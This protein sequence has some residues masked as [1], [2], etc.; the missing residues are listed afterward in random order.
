MKHTHLCRYATVVAS[1]LTLGTSALWAQAA[2]APSSTSPSAA[3]SEPT[4]RRN[5]VVLDETGQT[6]VKLTPFEVSSERETGYTAATTLAG[7]R[8]N[9]ELRD[10]GNAVSVITA[11]FL[12]DTGAV[13]N[14]S[15]LQYLTGT[16]VGNVHGNFTG[17]GDGALL[18]ET[19]KF[20]NPNQNTR[21]RGLAA[22]DNTRDYFLT[23]I[24]WDG[25]NV[26]RVDL[27]RGPNSILFGL[28]SP[29]G[30]I[31]TNTRQ[32]GFKNT[33]EAEFRF[34]SFESHRTTL[35]VNRVL[36]KDQ[37]AVRVSALR[38]D[39]K[40]K[41]EPAYDLDRRVFGALRF[42][43]AFLKRA[44]AR[45]IFKATVES[46]K[47]TSNRPRTLPPIDLITPWFQTGTYQ[48]RFANGSPRT[49]NNLNRETFNPFQLQDDN[50]GRPN[51]GQQRPSINGG[52]NAGQPNP[53]YNP[54]IG[55]F[56]QSFGGPLSYF[57]GGANTPAHFLSEI[58]AT[59][60]IGPTGAIDGNV[61]G[62]AF[63]RQGGIAP[64]ATFARNAN[65]PWSEFGVYKHNS[66]T[67]AS[68]F[69]FYKN[70]LDGPN[71][72]EW[73]NFTTYNLNLA[74]TFLNEKIGFEAVY[75][76][77]RYRN[78]QLSF[79]TDGRQA[80]HIDLNNVYTDGTPAGLNGEP[81]QNGTPNPNV[82]RPF[83]SD[84]GQF[85]NNSTKN[86]R[87]S[88]RGTVFA[89]HNFATENRR[90]LL[91]RILGRHT[92]TG[93]FAR[94]ELERDQ[95]EWQR[96]A[97]LDP[98][99]RTFIGAPSSI[100]FTDNL[101]APNPVIYLGDSLLNRAGS[102]GVNIPR[103]GLAA[104]PTSGTIRAFDS[105]WA[106]R[107]GVDPAAPWENEYYPVGHASRLSTQA[108][109]PANY[110]GW[111]S[112][113]LEITDSERTPGGRDALTTRARLT[114]SRISSRALVWQG[115]FWDKAIIGNIGWRRD[116]AQSWS[117]ERRADASPGFGQVDLGP[118]FRLPDNPNNRVE[119]SSRSYSIVSHLNQLPFVREWA[120]RAPVNVS[121]FYNKA[122]NFQPE[123]ARVDVYGSPLP[124]PAGQ[125]HDR[126]V[127]IE[128]KDGRFS[129][130]VNKYKTTITDGTS[131]ALAGAWFI[132]SSQAWG[133]NWANIFEHNLGGDT[134]STQGQ[135]NAGRYTY[136]P[137]PGETQEDADRRETAAVSAWRAWQRSVDP[138]F[139]Q[140]WGLNL[141]NLDRSLSAS[142]P[143]GFSVTEDYVSQGYEI[144]FNA[145]ATKNWRLTFNAS[146]T[147]A[148][149]QNIGGAALSQFIEAYE[150]ALRTTPAGDLRIWWGGA[151]NE[152]TL[153]QWNNNIGSEYAARK[154]QEGTNVPELR[155]WRFNV[156]TNYDFHE[157]RLRGLNV[158]GGLRW[159]DEV[160]I[161]YP[162]IAS[163][164]AGQANFDLSK[165]FFGPAE[166]NVDLWVGYGRR[167]VWRNVDWRIQ[168]NV[169]NAFAGNELIPITTQPDGTPAGYRIA[170]YQTWT[171]SNT[172]KF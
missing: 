106:N 75:N 171:V 111:R 166:T 146:K 80:I 30:I 17:V 28:G 172:F 96:W 9:T 87:E 128:T 149:R 123:A 41:Q 99:Y 39:E 158:G 154:L 3:S 122:D 138:R 141:N 54:W 70:L 84:S 42:E 68:V 108:E 153:F 170:P 93:L 103:A 36:L 20:T 15:L 23:D 16:E 117:F 143:P 145:Q 4:T 21:V 10:I 24:P 55:N 161:G 114:K 167:K 152:T 156:V 74:Q 94:D 78:G 8:L 72:N 22:A 83:I 64:Y 157:G 88:M 147:E 86:E 73:Q 168:L 32:A 137:A 144:E 11:Q 43:P 44:N 13:S 62:F 66:L 50:T 56:A 136:S 135:G 90:N 33:A 119:G 132:G 120:R 25:Y 52:P 130:K 6:I 126:G 71:K 112:V 46:G 34:G 67:D 116:V 97:I 31:N 79:M 105:T 49:F 51:H 148:V 35:D 134:I 100:R 125:T 129:L 121:V 82:G 60:G 18:N 110:V 92:L 81:F 113:P 169:R 14:E 95:R 155:E 40:F 142:A 140:V 47:I 48:G 85:G 26:D 45:T 165:P 76:Q 124:A 53:A 118:T 159:Q 102:S 131:S 163:T 59:R 162:P 65:L 115:Q 27:N 19:S 139:Y 160:V 151:G 101:L 1:A 164:T 38:D 29:A 63:H 107:P 58:R 5:D 109:N 2:P 104:I 89:T 133:G 127:L 57:N 37:L 69:D 61:G 91:T 98:A 12:K 7:N 150:R 77:E